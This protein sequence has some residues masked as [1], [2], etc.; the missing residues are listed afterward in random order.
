[1]SLKSKIRRIPEFKGVVFWDIC[2]LLRDKDAFKQAI[3]QLADHY[4][5][6]KIDAIASSE[7]RGFILGA[8]LAYELG[9]G[10][11]PIRKAGKLP[12]KVVRLTY[13]KEYESDTIE[14]HEDAVKRGQRVLLIDDVLATGGT[15]KANA[16]L[17]EKLGGKVVGM[18][19]LIE[20]D[21]LNGR[22]TI[23]DKYDVFAL[24]NFKTPEG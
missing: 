24:I 12:H 10:F 14:I 1:M 22:K 13:A 15:I 5:G 3:A 20:L 21:Y 18:G 6:K 23:G 4:R 17:I 11:V 19:F 9:V 8:A 2:T 7:A 16:E